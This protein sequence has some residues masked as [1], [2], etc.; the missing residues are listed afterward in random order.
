MR[1][2]SVAEV[3]A[4]LYART[5][6]DGC[7]EDM[8]FK[9]LHR[10]HVF[11]GPDFL[12]VGRPVM[13]NWPEEMLL[14]ALTTPENPDAWFIYFAKAVRPRKLMDF[15]AYEPYELPFIMFQ[16]GKKI[17]SYPRKCAFSLLS[18]FDRTQWVDPN[19]FHE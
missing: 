14:D 17:K 11:S 4:R 3:A 6:G 15:V 18:R 19:Q 8:I 2:R 5:F 1:Q 10:G 13:S 9:H 12:L 16:I 7:F